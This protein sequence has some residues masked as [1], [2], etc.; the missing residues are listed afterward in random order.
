MNRYWNNYQ[1]L[2]SPEVSI[3][4]VVIYRL[5]GALIEEQELSDETV[6]RIIETHQFK[7]FL[8]RRMF[9]VEDP[10]AIVR[11]GRIFTDLYFYQQ[12]L[13]GFELDD[14]NHNWREIPRCR[15]NMG[16]GIKKKPHAFCPVHSH[17]IEIS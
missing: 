14:T 11:V 1:I 16:T 13:W 5:N 2:N 7:Y 12:S 8:I 3:S 10:T 17:L 9:D 15:C 6:Q 4:G